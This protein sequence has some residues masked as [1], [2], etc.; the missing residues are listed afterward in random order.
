MQLRWYSDGSI[1]WMRSLLI[2]YLENNDLG[3]DTHRRNLSR[4]AF[5][6]VSS[7]RRWFAVLSAANWRMTRKTEV[8]RI[9]EGLP[10]TRQL[11]RG[12]SRSCLFCSLLMLL[13]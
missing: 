10:T 7:E 6:L 1:R 9:R 3:C 5:R 2:R 8:D 4:H 12:R 11:W 13:L